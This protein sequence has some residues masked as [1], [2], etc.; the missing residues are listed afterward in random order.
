MVIPTNSKSEHEMNQLFEIMGR[1]GG[2]KNMN[3]I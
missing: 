2:D 3:K 1:I